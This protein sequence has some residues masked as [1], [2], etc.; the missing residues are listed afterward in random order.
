SNRRWS[1]PGAADEPTPGWESRRTAHGRCS[2]E[3]TSPFGTRAVAGGEPPPP[4]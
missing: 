3:R 4:Q 1:G 2:A